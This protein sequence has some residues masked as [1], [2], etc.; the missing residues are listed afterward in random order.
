MGNGE[1]KRRPVR[2]LNYDAFHPKRNIAIRLEGIVGENG[3]VEVA[4]RAFAKW[5]CLPGKSNIPLFSVMRRKW[6][7]G[8]RK[9]SPG[10]LGIPTPPRQWG[11]SP[12]YLEGAE[13]GKWKIGRRSG[14]SL[15]SETLQAYGDI[16]LP[17]SL[18]LEGIW[19]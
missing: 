16:F 3:G 12:L 14:R 1:T 17:I 10:V 9:G 19:I 13:M 15:N 6:K 5:R 2:L 7:M 4:T 11:T 8:K 18:C